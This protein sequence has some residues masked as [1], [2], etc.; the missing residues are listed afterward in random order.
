MGREGLSLTIFTI[1]NFSPHQLRLHTT[2]SSFLKK[3]NMVCSCWPSTSNMSLSL[4]RLFSSRYSFVSKCLIFRILQTSSIF[5][6]ITE[7]VRT[8]TFSMLTFQ[9][10]KLQSD[11]G[12]LMS[13][14][15][16]RSKNRGRGI[17]SNVYGK[18]WCATLLSA[19]RLKHKM[20]ISKLL[21]SV[22]KWV[23]ALELKHGLCN[24]RYN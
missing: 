8:Q 2:F 19:T 6:I 5:G 17:G 11:D 15:Q 23:L 13:E 3:T 14:R 18:P 7:E 10:L 24:K 22:S 21:F 4:T 16:D 1:E 12:R 9:K 20:N